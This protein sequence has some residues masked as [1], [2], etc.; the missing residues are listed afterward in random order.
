[1][2]I[3]G[4]YPGAIG[5]VTEVHAKYYHEHWGFDSSFET[6]IAQELAK[7]V[8]AFRKDRDGLWIA[9]HGG[10]LTGSIAIDGR[11]VRTEGV[12]LRWFI[13]VPDFQGCGIGR[14]LLDRAV[15]FCRQK[16]YKVIFLWTF[17]GLAAAR[18]LYEHTGFR[19]SEAHEIEQWGNVLTEQKF[20]L[21]LQ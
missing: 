5:K 11:K 10:T 18:A 2:D 19:M 7:F 9:R 1:M 17:Q 20:E 8:H 15:E 6:Q 4:Y 16:G 12:R 21:L 3:T 13:V 14:Q